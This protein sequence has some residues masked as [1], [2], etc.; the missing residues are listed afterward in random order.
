MSGWQ[1]RNGALIAITLLH[2]LVLSVQVFGAPER[3]DEAPGI[4]STKTTAVEMSTESSV[5]IPLDLEAH[6]AAQ[7]QI[8]EANAALVF[9]AMAPDGR[10]IAKISA[11]YP[12]TLQFS[13]P[14][15]V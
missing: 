4:G 13:F 2:L 11:G 5:S 6:I 15:T 14:T 7:L 12:G 1:M 8:E 10:E 9:H 3:R